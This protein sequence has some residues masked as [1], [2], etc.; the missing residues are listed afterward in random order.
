M[1]AK[2]NQNQSIRKWL[3][4]RLHYFQMVLMI[5]VLIRLISMPLNLWLRVSTRTKHWT[6]QIRIKM[7]TKTI[8]MV[9]AKLTVQA[10]I[11]LLVVVVT[12]NACLKTRIWL[13]Y[14][15]HYLLENNNLL[16]NSMSN[17]EDHLQQVDRA[18]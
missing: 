12:R 14:K 9:F 7:D 3:K 16:Y 1:M 4:L 5:I 8:K 2:N 10:W 17:K 13:L 11:N 6:I 18:I 15:K